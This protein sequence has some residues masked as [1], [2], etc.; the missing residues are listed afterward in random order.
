MDCI[1]HATG[2][3]KETLLCGGEW[4]PF[5]PQYSVG[6]IQSEPELLA[7]L[8]PNCRERMPKD[9]QAYRQVT[10]E[11]LRSGKAFF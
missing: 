2:K 7:A 8:C 1:I 10:P 3:K 11:M 9:R 5:V 4:S 6:F